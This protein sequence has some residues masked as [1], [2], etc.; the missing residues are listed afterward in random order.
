MPRART[1]A[2][3][4]DARP[5]PAATRRRREKPLAL[6]AWCRAGNEGSPPASPF[7][8]AA[9]PCRSPAPTLR[10][11]PLH[12]PLRRACSLAQRALFPASYTARHA[13]LLHGFLR[14]IVFSSPHHLP[15]PAG[16]RVRRAL[17]VSVV[18]ERYQ[19]GGLLFFFLLFSPFLP[20]PQNR[21]I[22]VNDAKQ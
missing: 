19:I 6:P 18:T 3:V 12:L 20:P 9:A 14:R 10:A 22:P 8:C 1:P 13:R 11:R 16:R 15:P 17:I 7:A 2:W 21:A 4:G 5:R